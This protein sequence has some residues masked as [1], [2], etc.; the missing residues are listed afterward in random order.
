TLYGKGEMGI[1]CLYA[2]LFDDRVQQVILNDAP[3]SHWV[4][5]ALMNVLRVSDVPEVAGAFAPRRL[6]SLT[7]LPDSF[8]LTRSV[9]RLKNASEKLVQAGSLPEAMEVWKKPNKSAVSGHSLERNVP[10]AAHFTTGAGPAALRGTHEIVLTGNASVANPFDTVAR[11][12][13]TP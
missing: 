10:P 12:Q 3:G 13:F 11:V 4:G 9:Y 7:R 1:V 8:E 6:V 5:P 2:A